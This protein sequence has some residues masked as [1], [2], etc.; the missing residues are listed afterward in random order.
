MSSAT[1]APSGANPSTNAASITPTQGSAPSATGGSASSSQQLGPKSDTVVSVKTLLDAGAHFGHQT[2]RWNPK[3]MPYIYTQRNGVHIID[4]DLTMRAWERA[5]KFIA[6]KVAIGGSLLFVGTKLQGREIVISEAAR[7]GAFHI[8][9]RWLGGTLTNF[10]TI[11]NSID[12]MRKLEELLAK[13]NDEKS[14]VKLNK[15]E[16]LTIA[17]DLSKLE[18]NLGGIRSMR[19]VPDVLFVMDI[20]KEAIAVSEARRLHIPVVALVD[21]NTDPSVVDFAIPSNDDSARTLR[22]FAS[23]VAD[24]VLDGRE[25]FEARSTRGSEAAGGGSET[26][27]GTQHGHHTRDAASLQVGATAI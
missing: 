10:Q 13:A 4:L 19:R 22:L 20:N 5:R 17:R 11:K 12:R 15:K 25:A 9:S 7:C 1:D 24:A 21:T 8:T 3:M 23:A 18:A 6:D 16:R 27:G 26:N 14:E 2:E